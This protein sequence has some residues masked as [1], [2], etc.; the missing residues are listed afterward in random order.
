MRQ[1]KDVLRLQWSRWLSM[2]SITRSLGVACRSVSDALQRAKATRLRRPLPTP[3][4][5]TG[6]EAWWDSLVFATVRAPQ[7]LRNALSMD[8]TGYRMV[9]PESHANARDYLIYAILDEIQKVGVAVMRWVEFLDPKNPK[10]PQ[11]SDQISRV[12]LESIIDEQ[13]RWKRKLTEV[14]INSICF[15]QTNEDAYY[16]Y[17]LTLSRLE[18]H[19][20]IQQDLEEFYSCPSRNNES[21]ITPVA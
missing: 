1:I 20:S 17:F 11:A 14:L 3:Q 16:R 6:E 8:E 13:S 19:L 4:P 5:R 15:D 10:P 21:S 18:H 7:D 12:I 9:A 2:R